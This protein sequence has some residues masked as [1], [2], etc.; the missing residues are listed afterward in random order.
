M[1]ID[2]LFISS[3]LISGA[4]SF[5]EVVKLVPTEFVQ[6]EERGVY[7]FIKNYFRE[8]KGI[9]P[10]I[11]AVKTKFDTFIPIKPKDSIHFYVSELKER[12]EYELL[13]ESVTHIQN[14]LFVK[15]VEKAKEE[16]RK[17]GIKLAGLEMSEAVTAKNNLSD[18][19]KDYKKAKENKG[20][21]GYKTGLDTFDNI[22]GGITDEMFIIMGKRGLGKTFCSLFIANNI[23]K[24]LPKDKP[25]LYISNEMSVSK[26]T[27]RLDSAVGEFNYSRYRKGLL[28]K[29][30]I[31]KLKSLRRI[32]EERSEFICISGVGKSVDEIEY[33]IINARPGLLVCDGLYLTD[34]GKNDQYKDTASAS[35]AYQRLTKRYDLPAILT[36]QITNEGEAKYARAIEE[37]ADVVVKMHQSPAMKTDTVMGFDFAKVREED[38]DIKTF[39]TWDFENWVF[40]ENAYDTADSDEEQEYD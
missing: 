17:I 8:S 11:S 31:Q 38:S 16:Y 37:D 29:D 21:I 3:I 1:D 33:E 25:V 32:Y 15:D 19:I 7:T 26:I 2:N 12:T 27:K 14:N 20:E 34:M 13:T 6:G 40:K 22:L 35:R 39:M 9:L 24:Q 5:K 28:K 23:W 30:E 4:E 18:R 36:T 10:S